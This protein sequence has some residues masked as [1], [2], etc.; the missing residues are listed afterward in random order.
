MAAECANFE[1]V[2]MARLLEV[3]TAGIY[4]WRAGRRCR[5]RSAGL[6]WTPRA[7]DAGGTRP[8]LHRLSEFVTGQHERTGLE[9]PERDYP[10]LSTVE[11]CVH[12]LSASMG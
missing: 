12:Y 11:G 8:R 9:I 4:R 10:E 1:I 7:D 2:R 6:I 5:A 3:A